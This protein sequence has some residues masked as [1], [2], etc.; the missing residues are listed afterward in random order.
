MMARRR[1]TSCWALFGATVLA[2]V[3][4]SRSSF[5]FPTSR[6]TYV[7]GSGAEACPDETAVRQAVAARLGYDPFFPSAEKTIVA[8][9]V[10]TKDE[11]R[12]TVELVDEHGLMRGV[13][14][15]RAS[16]GQCG[17]LVATMALAIS[18]AIDPT[19][20][21]IL[22]AAPPSKQADPQTRKRDSNTGAAP[23]NEQDVVPNG[24]AD[25]DARRSGQDAP[26]TV[27]TDRAEGSPNGDA[28]LGNAPPP[29][30]FQFRPGATVVVAF[31]TAPAPTMGFA[32]SADLR[33]GIWSIH[34]EGRIDPPASTDGTEGVG[35]VRTSL[36]TVALGPCLHF[37]PLFVCATAW[38]GSLR[39]EGVALAAPRTDSTLYAA[40]GTRVGLE[41]PLNDRFAFRPE[42][43]L[44]TTLLPV[45]LQVD[46]VA[47]WQAPRFAVLLGVGLMARF[48]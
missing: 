33:R 42:L 24:D 30:P 29:T 23:S 26:T 15:L 3:C 39:A 20:P 43:D 41:L 22:G 4:V 40:A 47:A 16:A 10:R 36:W 9:I 2:V 25:R 37:D 45:E 38:I 44:Q 28:A 18:I 17:E 19:N 46:G 13:R 7:R 31:G 6:L 35:R 1:R 12:A 8:R 14:E 5:A 11:L 34:L 32:L 48:P 21:A 27:S